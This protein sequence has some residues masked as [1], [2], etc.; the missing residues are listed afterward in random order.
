MFYPVFQGVT[1]ITKA[2][3]NEIYQCINSKSPDVP[4]YVK[5]AYIADK[6]GEMK[7][8]SISVINNIALPETLDQYDKKYQNCTT[9]ERFINYYESQ[10]SKFYLPPATENRYYNQIKLLRK[11]QSLSQALINNDETVIAAARLD[12]T[13]YMITRYLDEALD[14]DDDKLNEVAENL[15]E[16]KA[17]IEKLIELVHKITT[18]DTFQPFAEET[19]IAQNKDTFKDYFE[20]CRANQNSEMNQG[21]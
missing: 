5:L 13:K 16:N 12:L 17:W 6:Y 14:I 15:L 8:K 21:L 10:E 20:K 19:V 3:I 18:F 4:K 7:K 2:V 9:L 1:V 11:S